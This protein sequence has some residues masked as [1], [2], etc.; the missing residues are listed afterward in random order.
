MIARLYKSLQVTI[1]PFSLPLVVVMHVVGIVGLLSPYQELFR[2]LTPLNL[3]ASAFLLWINHADRSASFLLFAFIVFVLGFAVE[4]V[5]VQYG[6]IFG[7]YTYG[8]TLGPKVFGVPV[9][10][11]L[12]WLLVIYCIGVLTESLTLPV[13]PKILL[14]AF[15]AVLMDTLIEPVAIRFDFWGWQNGVVP[16]QNYIGWFIVSAAMLAFFHAFK[17]KAE[18]KLAL[19]YYFV[20]LFF[21]LILASA[22]SVTAFFGLIL[23]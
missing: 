8:S 10:I 23:Y 2:L 3:V 7:Q 22:K 16:L 19:P 14:G 11:G 21:F 12:N 9:I 5:G 17:I 1:C 20:Q 13:L 18:N 4:V 6:F 15:L